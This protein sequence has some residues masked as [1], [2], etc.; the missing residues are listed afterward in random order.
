MERNYSWAADTSS[1]N[2]EIPLILWNLDVRCH[3]QNMPPLSLFWTRFIQS[4]IFHAIY[5]ESIFIFS[6]LCLGFRNVLCHSDFPTKI[7]YAFLFSQRCAICPTSLVLLY[8][9]TQILYCGRSRRPCCLKRRSAAARLLGLRVRILLRAWILNEWINGFEP[10][11][12]PIHLGHPN[13][14]GHGYCSLV[15]VV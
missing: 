8:V 3:V 9:L 10:R 13:R 12:I 6:H 7:L 14:L 15:F 4:S 1:G 2:Q 11:P 5:L